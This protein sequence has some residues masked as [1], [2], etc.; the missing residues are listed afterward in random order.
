LNQKYTEV[1]SQ[2]SGIFNWGAIINGTCS[3][4]EFFSPKVKLVRVGGDIRVV[5]Q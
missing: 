3:Q 1:A 4:G 2:E 5:V